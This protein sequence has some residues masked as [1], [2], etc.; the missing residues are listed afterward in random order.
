MDEETI[1]QMPTTLELSPVTDHDPSKHPVLLF[2]HY[3]EYLLHC[4]LVD[5]SISI[6][7]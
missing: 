1:F 5:H 3:D 6:P 7:H 2:I 4:C